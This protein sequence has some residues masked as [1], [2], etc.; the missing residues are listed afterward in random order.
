MPPFPG[1]PF[2][3]LGQGFALSGSENA[4]QFGISSMD[5]LGNAMQHNPAHA[6]APDLPL[7]ILQ[8]IGA[9]VKIVAPE[10]MHTGTIAEQ[11]CNCPYCQITRAIN[12]DSDSES[13][14]FSD[15]AAWSDGQQVQASKD[16]QEIL[17]PWQIQ[18]TGEKQF[19]V[20][21]TATRS[22]FRVFLGDPV[23]CTCGQQGCEHIIAVLKS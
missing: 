21:D 9:I 14:L 5:G 20:T 1:L 8:K 3:L 17:T 7:E 13:Q 10:E 19:L 15:I 22:E 23:G 4:F 18:E 12:G 11:D 6:N 2:G 16:P